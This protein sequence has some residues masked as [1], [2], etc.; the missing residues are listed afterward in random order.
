VAFENA[1]EAVRE[2]FPHEMAAREWEVGR[3]ALME[4]ERAYDQAQKLLAQARER[5]KKQWAALVQ[6]A[7][8][9]DPM[10]SISRDR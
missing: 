2:A 5:E 1:T 7:G 4:A 9:N 8:R 3:T 6:A 10:P